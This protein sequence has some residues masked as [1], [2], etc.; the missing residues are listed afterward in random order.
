MS[1]EAILFEDSHA[2]FRALVTGIGE[3]VLTGTGNQLSPRVLFLLRKKSKR[4]I[5][6]NGSALYVRR[7]FLLN[8]LI[9][10]SVNRPNGS[11]VVR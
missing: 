6:S 11:S 4:E 5:P 1:A 9:I 2:N 8:P 10:R 7:N 3:R